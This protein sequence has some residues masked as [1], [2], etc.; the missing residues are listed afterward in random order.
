MKQFSFLILS[1]FL[2]ATLELQGVTFLSF[3]LPLMVAVKMMIR[4][5]HW[6]DFTEKGK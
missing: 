5:L 4:V 2:K 3:A 1:K 6:W